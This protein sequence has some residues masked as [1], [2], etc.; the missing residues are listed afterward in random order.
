MDRR[1]WRI[2]RN[3]TRISFSE[4]DRGGCTFN[5]IVDL[6]NI[7]I[8]IRHKG[9]LLSNFLENLENVFLWLGLGLWDEVGWSDIKVLVMLDL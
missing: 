9:E 3:D 4:E 5:G 6:A 8:D 2:F 1:G 7:L